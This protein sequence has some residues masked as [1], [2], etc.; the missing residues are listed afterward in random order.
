MTQDNPSC[1]IERE[2][3]TVRQRERKAGRQRD[4]EINGQKERVS[5]MVKKVDER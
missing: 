5:Q 3:Q 1:H 2:R 4:K